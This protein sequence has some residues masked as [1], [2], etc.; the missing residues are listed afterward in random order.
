VNS[1]TDANGVYRN[2]LGITD[3]DQLRKIEYDI[4]RSRSFEIL[5]RGAL[6]H[7]QGFGLA[8]QQA[9]HQ[10]LFQ[11]VYEWAG[12][13]RTVPS[14]KRME[15]GMVSIFANPGD[16]ES[17]WRELEKKTQ[18]FTGAKELTFEQKREALADIFIEANSIHPFPE[19]NGRSL[20]VF[21]KEFARAQD[22]DLDFNKINPQEWN[23][24]SAISGTYG[25][26]FEENKQKY[27]IPIP[28]DPEPIKKIFAEMASPAREF[29][30][31]KNAGAASVVKAFRN[32]PP[33]KA[34]QQHTELAPAYGY[35]RACEAKAEADGLDAQQRAIVM[36]RVSQN[37]A[38]RI[39][40]GHVPNVQV[41]EEKQIKDKDKPRER[42]PE[43]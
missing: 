42:D 36:A 40:Q 7:V 20:Q 25:E 1:Y 10:Y 39:E 9:I 37:V 32:E 23:K 6:S 16:I 24:A 18:A 8:R 35:L 29:E 41:R 12:K 26:L 4:T 38:E 14:S 33:E 28:S 13:T 30:Q 2:K 3:V 19:G 43:R 34:I 17:A 27:L 31:I 22:V 5:E 11:D 21:M 15:N